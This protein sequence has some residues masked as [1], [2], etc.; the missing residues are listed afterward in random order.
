M[1]WTLLVDSKVERKHAAAASALRLS[2]SLA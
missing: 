1:I 2:E